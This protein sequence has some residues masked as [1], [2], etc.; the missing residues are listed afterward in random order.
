MAPSEMASQSPPPAYSPGAGDDTEVLSRRADPNQG[1]TQDAVR[2]AP[3]GE[4]STA[5]HMEEMIPTE[6]GEEGH[7]QFGPQPNMVTETH[8]APKSG[9]RPPLKEGGAP[10]PPVAPVKPGAPDN[11]MEN[12]LS[13]AI[14]RVEKMVKEEM[15][16][17]RRGAIL[18][19]CLSGLV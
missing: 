5:G 3:R 11:L 4:A 2:E 18:A 12:G 13:E 16:E 10:I 15:G 8:T 6:T 17:R 1:G 14:R 7:I 9:E 19:R